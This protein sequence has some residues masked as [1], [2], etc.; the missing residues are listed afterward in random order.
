MPY[1]TPNPSRPFKWACWLTRGA[2]LALFSVGLRRLLDSSSQAIQVLM[3]LSDRAA[4]RS[5]AWLDWQPVL[6]SLFAALVLVLLGEC[7]LFGGMPLIRLL[8]RAA[9]TRT[10]APNPP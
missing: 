7:L 2:G 5:S 10:P 3:G 8:T 4:M 1:R 9:A 6:H